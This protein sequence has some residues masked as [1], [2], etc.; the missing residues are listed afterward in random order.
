M[1]R[2]YSSSGAC[3]VEI[4]SD[5]ASEVLHVDVVVAVVLKGEVSL[6]R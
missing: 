3:A 6:G 2:A 4:F 5:C 1:R